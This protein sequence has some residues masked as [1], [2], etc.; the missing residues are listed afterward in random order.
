M[1]FNHM[2]TV[3]HARGPSTQNAILVALGH[4]LLGFPDEVLSL[5]FMDCKDDFWEA[6]FR[7]SAVCRRFRSIVYSAPKMWSYVSTR[8]A[9]PE[10]V[11]ICLA[12]SQNTGLHLGI[13]EG[14]SDFYLAVRVHFRRWESIYVAFGGK[15]AKVEIEKLLPYH[16][17]AL[18]AFPRLKSVVFGPASRLPH[19][20]KNLVELW[21]IS[22]QNL[23]HLALTIQT[24]SQY[25]M[26]ASLRRLNLTVFPK[27]AARDGSTHHLIMLLQ[28][29]PLLED[30]NLDLQTERFNR[31]TP[32]KDRGN[33]EI[34]IVSMPLVEKVTLSFH[35]HDGLQPLLL[36]L[37]FP[38]VN[39]LCI[40]ICN[41]DIGLDK[42]PDN[43][44]DNVRP[45]FRL[46]NEIFRGNRKYPKLSTLTLTLL[47]GYE[48]IH[49]PNVVI[50]ND[51]IMNYAKTCPAPLHA[52]L[53]HT[54]QISESS[55]TT[56]LETHSLPPSRCKLARGLQESF[57]K[58]W[59][60][61]FV[62]DVGDI[63][64]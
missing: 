40:N 10:I 35:P 7:L 45:G 14:S 42:D 24:P 6:A 63:P 3:V 64:M 57:T 56:Q 4:G 53:R 29:A 31:Y 26:P 23:H 50:D 9:R 22:A 33:Q 43:D 51:L 41:K 27:Q 48:A 1:L 21:K 58:G 20:M 59:R 47:F 38:N 2:D 19:E 60:M 62:R 44:I 18:D 46:L 55:P 17:M 32:P 36:A 28:S 25:I 8:M 12:R 61:V 16:Y 11:D 39:D 13:W 49:H 34:K 15:E 37:Y 52:S 30:I 54:H 5:V